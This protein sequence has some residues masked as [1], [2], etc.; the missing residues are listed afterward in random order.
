MKEFYYV[1]TPW[2]VFNS[3][4]ELVDTNKY[5]YKIKKE[6]YDNQ[7]KAK[8]ARIE[9]LEGMILSVSEEIKE[10]EESRDKD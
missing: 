5:E 1:S 9:A 2:G 8:K 4:L 3:G 7:I 6:W 10:L